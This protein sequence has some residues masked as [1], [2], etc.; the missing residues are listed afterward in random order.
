MNVAWQNYESLHPPRKAS[1]DTFE[2]AI[3]SLLTIQN[4]LE[5]YL[6]STDASKM[7][8]VGEKTCSG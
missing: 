8:Q 2:R 1:I 5:Q 3:A 4:E 6:A 7:E